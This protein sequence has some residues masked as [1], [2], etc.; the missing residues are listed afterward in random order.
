[1]SERP[2]KRWH[3][4]YENINQAVK[5]MEALPPEYQTIVAQAINLIAENNLTAEEAV[6]SIGKDKI[7]S[8]FKSKQKQRSYDK[9]TDFH[10]TMNYLHALAER[11]RRTLGQLFLDLTAG[12]VKYVSNCRERGMDP[13]REVIENMAQLFMHSN[14]SPHA[15]DAYIDKIHPEFRQAYTPS[16][17][18]EVS[19]GQRA[20]Q[21]LSAEEASKPVGDGVE[22]VVDRQGDMRIQQQD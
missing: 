8:L 18:L 19:S 15:L 10:K 20:E 5:G 22:D 2:S 4:Q 6:R 12:T 13:Q 16:A 3:D 1:M 9:N 11:E 14:G 7:M 17:S 21:T